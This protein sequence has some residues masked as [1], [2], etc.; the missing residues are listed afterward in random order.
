MIGQFANSVRG[1]LKG[2]FRNARTSLNFG[3]PEL[4]SSNNYDLKKADIFSLGVT[5]LCAFYLC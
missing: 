3:A 1:T 4:N 5:L 2:N